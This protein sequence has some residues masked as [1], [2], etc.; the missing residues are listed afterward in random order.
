MVHFYQEG[1][2]LSGVISF[3][4][5]GDPLFRTTFPDTEIAKKYGSGKIGS[6][7]S[8][9]FVFGLVSSLKYCHFDAQYEAVLCLFLVQQVSAVLEVFMLE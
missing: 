3:S 5:A 9:D 6:P 7:G 2:E 1:Q 8:V 4:Y